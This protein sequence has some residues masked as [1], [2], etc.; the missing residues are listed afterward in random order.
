[1]RLIGGSYFWNFQPRKQTLIYH[2]LTHLDYLAK[3]RSN[4]SPFS[5]LTG[6]CS[7]HRTSPVTLGGFAPISRSPGQESHG[8]CVLEAQPPCP[9]WPQGG[10][11]VPG[12][13]HPLPVSSGVRHRLLPPLGTGPLGVGRGDLLTAARRSR[14]REGRLW[15]Q[16]SGEDRDS[17]RRSWRARAWPPNPEVGGASPATAPS[18]SCPHSAPMRMLTSARAW[19]TSGPPPSAACR[20]GLTLHGL[21]LSGS[22]HTQAP[23]NPASLTHMWVPRS[24]LQNPIEQNAWECPG[25]RELG[26]PLQVGRAG[27]TGTRGPSTPGQG[28][29]G[30]SPGWPAPRTVAAGPSPLLEMKCLESGVAGHGLPA[31]RSLGNDQALLFQ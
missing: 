30:D 20:Q 21:T 26:M 10:A 4:K 31:W 28:D 25:S 13:D 12:G 7:L 5:R 6:P 18:A 24:L 11:G 2:H 14:G 29:T 17:R 9:R 8:R 15:S 16:V 23:R 27:G 19:E 22:P 3:I 1:M